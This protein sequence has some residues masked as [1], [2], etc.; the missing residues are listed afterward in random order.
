MGLLKERKNIETKD[1]G[2][3]MI[4]EA[5]G[6]PPEYLAE[7]LN[8]I[9]TRID[10]EEGVKVLSKK[11]NESKLM[12]DQNNFYTNFAEIEIE[13][14]EILQL[15]KLIIK[16]MPAHVEIIYP[17]FIAL[18]NNGWND[19]FNE[20]LLKLH[21][22]DEV[23][24]IIQV[25]KEILEDKLRSV[26]NEKKSKSTENKN[27]INKKEETKSDEEVKNKENWIIVINEIDIINW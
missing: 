2:V 5:I 13:I 6:R 7:V 3:F 8:D 17:E 14:E 11:V 9:I 27:N 21:G 19:I 16:Y 1:I 10:N 4:I 18:T 12:K 15:G 23:A 24:R 22:Y 26:L 20:I 25:E